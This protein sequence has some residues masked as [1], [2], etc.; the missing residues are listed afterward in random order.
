MSENEAQGT[1]STSD[2]PQAGSTDRTFTQDQL[3]SMLAEQKRKT[4]SRYTDYDDLKAKAAELDQL[5]DSQKSEL[6]KAVDQARKDAATEVEGKYLTRLAAAEVK[7]MAAKR[8]F[9][10]P[11]DAVS[12]LGDLS[13]LLSEGD[14][15][16]EV[17]DQQL[18][19][20]AKSKP[21]LVNEAVPKPARRSRIPGG[22]SSQED[23]TKKTKAA[24]ALR[25]FAI[26]R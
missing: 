7:S 25:A 21:Y 2:E 14:V 24:D 17:V 6:D 10:D 23:T 4:E 22:E 8:G 9:H 26:S 1:E 5:K 15:N 11:A 16:P 20:L 18:K 19:E 12:M 3:N 13:A